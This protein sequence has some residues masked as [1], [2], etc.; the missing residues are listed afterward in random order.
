[1]ETKEACP[2]HRAVYDVCDCI[3]TCNTRTSLHGPE[4]RT[5]TGR[6]VSPDSVILRDW[7]GVRR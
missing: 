3:C 7:T 2:T 4:C 6:T 1:M 5:Y